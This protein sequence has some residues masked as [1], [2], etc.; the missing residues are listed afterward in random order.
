MGRAI[1]TKATFVSSKLNNKGKMTHT[2]SIPQNVFNELETFRKLI[3]PTND[4]SQEDGKLFTSWFS[5][6]DVNVDAETRE[7]YKDLFG[8][9]KCMIS[10]IEKPKGFFGHEMASF[11]NLTVGKE[12]TLVFDVKYFNV[13]QVQG[14]SCTLMSV[15]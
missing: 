5:I 12:S 15:Q 1:T 8:E 11:P 10:F 7:K 4:T 6:G 3:K 9:Q 14:F 2:F 13:S